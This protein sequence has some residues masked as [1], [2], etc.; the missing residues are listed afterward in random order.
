MTVGQ[1]FKI[2]L[3]LDVSAMSDV[4]RT[5]NK[6]IETPSFDRMGRRLSGVGGFSRTRRLL[7]HCAAIATALMF[8]ILPVELH[9]QPQ[10][11]LTS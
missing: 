11:G 4:E 8:L 9:L 6:Q 7:K 10:A 5:I 1:L 2:D 3:T